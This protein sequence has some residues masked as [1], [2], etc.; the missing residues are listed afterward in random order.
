MAKIN[1]EEF[2]QKIQYLTEIKVINPYFV[3]NMK[4][5]R[6]INPKGLRG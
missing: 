2:G 3:R 1:L 5:L 4:N 6:E